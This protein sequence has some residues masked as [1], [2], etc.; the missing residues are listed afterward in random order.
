MTWANAIYLGNDAIA[1]DACASYTGFNVE[2]PVTM[3]AN[4]TF[5]AMNSEIEVCMTVP[6]DG[7]MNSPAGKTFLVTD[8]FAKS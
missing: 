2:F 8:R 6:M 5:D 3:D 4:S 7:M 1:T